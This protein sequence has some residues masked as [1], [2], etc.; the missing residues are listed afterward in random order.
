MKKKILYVF[1][2]LITFDLSAL[3]IKTEMIKS[4]YNKIDYSTLEVKNLF[5]T[6]DDELILENVSGNTYKYTLIIDN[7]ISE[8]DATIYNSKKKNAIEYDRNLK[9]G[10]YLDITKQLIAFENSSVTKKFRNYNPEP[11]FLYIRNLKDEIIF[12][13]NQ[14]KLNHEEYYPRSY[15]NSLSEKIFYTEEGRER[16]MKINAVYTENNLC[17]INQKKNKIAIILNNYNSE[18]LNGLIILDVLYNATVND[19]RVRLRSEPNLESQTLSYFYTGDDVK[20]IAQ[21]DEKYEIDGESWYW[22]K[23]ESGS[24]PVGLVYGKYLDIEKE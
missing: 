21:S 1:I 4:G 14:W 15:Y 2:L 10:Y 12:N 16:I 8:I 22:Y 23:V 9:Y 17:C 13:F 19:L 11:L 6:K 7:Y 18:G 20:I 24:Y 5:F 3:E